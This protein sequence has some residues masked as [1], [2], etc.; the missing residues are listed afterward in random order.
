MEPNGSYVGW[1]RG[2]NVSDVTLTGGGI[3]DGGGGIWRE[4]CDGACSLPQRP[5]MLHF[6]GMSRTHLHNLRV[7][8]SGFWTIHFQYSSDIVVENMSVFNAAG[9]NAD[10]IDI[11][12]SRRA[13]VRESS[14]DV[15]DDMLCVK[16]GKNW[17]AVSLPPHPTASIS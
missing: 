8:N 7:Q 17:A 6:E 15:G 14:W 12:S 13:L 3:L 1:L 16:S 9:G 4:M 10:G 2:Y 11:D 5:Y